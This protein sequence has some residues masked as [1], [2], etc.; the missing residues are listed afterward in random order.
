MMLYSYFMIESS[1][2]SPNPNQPRKKNLQIKGLQ[3]QKILKKG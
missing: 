3:Y 1:A 2:T